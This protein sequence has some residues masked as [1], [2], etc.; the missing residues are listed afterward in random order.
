[1]RI[2]EVN[3]TLDFDVPTVI[4]FNCETERR[5]P[6]WQ[7]WPNIGNGSCIVNVM[8][9]FYASYFKE[10]NIIKWCVSLQDNRV[11][12]PIR[13]R[14]QQCVCDTRSET[15]A[16][17]EYGIGGESRPEAGVRCRARAAACS[18]ASSGASARARSASGCIAPRASAAEAACARPAAHCPRALCSASP[19]HTSRRVTCNASCSARMSPHADA[20]VSLA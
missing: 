10:K 17:S 5:F 3:Q 8:F 6:W 18:S 1:M 14:E 15:A 19:S 20:S 11:L 12:V 13:V 7:Y 4:Y 2:S 9:W 16:G